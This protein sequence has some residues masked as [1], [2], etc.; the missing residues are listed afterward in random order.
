MRNRWGIDVKR[1]HFVRYSK[2]RGGQSEGRVSAIDRTSEM[3]RAY[4]ARVLLEGGG[5]CGIDDVSMS[6]G[7][8][9]I[10]RDGSVKQNPLSRVK[11]GSPSQ[12]GKAPPSARLR[13]RR[14]VTVKAPQGYYAN[15]TP[16]LDRADQPSQR[17][18]V[19]PK[20]GRETKRAT[21]R[22]QQRRALTHYQ[23][24][25]GVWANPVD[26]DELRDATS[27]GT[28]ATR[29]NLKKRLA[30]LAREIGTTAGPM[31]GQINL[32]I[33]NGGYM[34]V[35]M[36][37]DFGAETSLSGRLSAGEMLTYLD[38]AILVARAVK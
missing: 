25:P 8:M 1:G 6:L 7:P 21:K 37:S 9:T 31:K 18:H 14:R 32:D 33:A 11:V 29:E 20:T 19:D 2:P 13:K 16:R 3:A 23:R 15:P 34:L 4:G 27:Y 28:K 5:S 38:G 17:P 26:F 24:A 35:Q 36:K 10:G 30:V 22:L 12:L